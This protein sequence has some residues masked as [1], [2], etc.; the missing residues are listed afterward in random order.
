MAHNPIHL[1][2]PT[3]ILART[4][5]NSGTLPHTTHALRK[6]PDVPEESGEDTGFKT[7]IHPGSLSLLLLSYTMLFENIVAKTLIGCVKPGAG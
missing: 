7:M 2:V 3:L 6:A 4:K 1:K 5:Q